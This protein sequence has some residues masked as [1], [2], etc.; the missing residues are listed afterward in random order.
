MVRGI[1]AGAQ[2]P[3]WMTERLRRSGLRAIHPVVDV[4]NYVMLELGQPLHAY[5]LEKLQGAIRPRFARPGERVLLLDERTVDLR[6]DTVVITDDSGPIGL[7]G[8][9]GG[10]TTAVSDTT[11]NVFFEA[12]FW[13]QDVMAGR[14]RSYGLHTDASLR[15]ERGVDPGLPPRAVARAV[16]LLVAIAGGK[17]GPPADHLHEEMLPDRHAVRLRRTRLES[18]LGTRIDAAAVTDILLGLQ[19]YVRADDEGWTVTPPGFRF[20]IVI[21]EDLIEEVARIHGYDRIAEA[22]AHIETPLVPVTETRV[23]LDRVASV[24][25]ARDYQEVITWSFVDAD[26]NALLTGAASTLELS[27]PISSDLSVMRG[28]LWAGMLRTANSNLA[29]QQERVRLFEIGKSYHGTLDEPVEI[30]RVA[31]A[32]LGPVLPE[33]WGGKPQAIDFFDIKSDVEALVATTG[34][35]ECFDFEAADHPAL[36]PGQAARILRDGDEA[37]VIGKLH[38]AVARRLDMK[39]DVF[40][41]EL[42]AAIVF[43]ARV[44]AASPVSRFPA[45]RRDIA[46]VVDDAVSAAQLRTAVAGVAPELVRDVIVFDVYRG[47]GIEAGLKSVALGLILQETSRTLTDADADSVLDAAVHKL[48]QEFTAVLRD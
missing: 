43:A 42:D 45:I 30:V 4:T 2:S 14:A 37:G 8:I 9:M 44:P 12:A 36:Q 23:D 31:G 41:F 22:T 32:A 20:D 26:S 11:C 48:Q 16:E 5:D 46:V 35:P 34:V 25:L 28:T 1:D 24:L 40:L 15:F 18:L 6:D 3:L 47:P 39:K 13:P 29:R 27:N 19:F 33:Q 21:E 17:A 7:A 38:P 10:L